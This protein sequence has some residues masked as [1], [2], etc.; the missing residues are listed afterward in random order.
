[1]KQQTKIED[2]YPFYKGCCHGLGN[3]IPVTSYALSCA[4]PCTDLHYETQAIIYALWP[5]VRILAPRRWSLASGHYFA[6][7][8]FYPPHLVMI[9]ISDRCV[10]GCSVYV[11]NVAE[12]YRHKAVAFS[13][14]VCSKRLLM[15][16]PVT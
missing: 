4:L 7:Y 14:L 8:R 9:P 13:R 10:C 3:T 15:Q 6:I 2:E 1:M 12:Y 5:N 16:R 11:T